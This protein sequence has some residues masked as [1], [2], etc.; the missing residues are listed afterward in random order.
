MTINRLIIQCY[1]FRQIF[2]QVPSLSKCKFKISHV[3]LTFIY[4]KNIEGDSQLMKW[5]CSLFLLIVNGCTEI[6]FCDFNL[7]LFQGKK[8]CFKVKKTIIFACLL[9]VT[10]CIS[11]IL[12]VFVRYHIFIKIC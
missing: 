6:I 4:L 3:K 10:S 11:Q 1:N 8:H 9:Y 7:V 5:K 2:Y 12:F